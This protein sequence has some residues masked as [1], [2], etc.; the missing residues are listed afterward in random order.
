[1]AASIVIIRKTPKFGAEIG[2]LQIKRLHTY[3]STKTRGI[4]THNMSNVRLTW[5]NLI[6][7][8][9]FFRKNHLSV[10][11]AEKN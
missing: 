8:V 3:F 4:T 2:F 1:M 9:N 10:E 11:F 5:Q 6:Q 7:A